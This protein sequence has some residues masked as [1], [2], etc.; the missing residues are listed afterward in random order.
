MK[1]TQITVHQVDLPL[2]EGTYSWSGGQSIRVYDSTVVR[3]HT[4]AGLIGHGEVCPLGP[5]YLPAY[6][7]GV[8]SGLAELAPHL[9]GQDPRQLGVKGALDRR[10]SGTG[11]KN[12]QPTEKDC[13]ITNE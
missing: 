7:S 11:P 5:A 6:A 2:R 4:D 1:I 9:L 8:R 3:I 12:T 10:P 13:I